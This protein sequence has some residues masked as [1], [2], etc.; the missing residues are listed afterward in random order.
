MDAGTPGIYPQ[1]DIHKFIE[2][3]L[4]DY[5]HDA[6]GNPIH[7]HTPGLKVC[8]A[9]PGTGDI[10]YTM[11]GEQCGP[12]VDIATFDQQAVAAW[13]NEGGD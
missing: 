13:H 10:W 6:N 1:D 12:D 7:Y 11:P 5:K 3:N 4:W 8:C 2:S 9:S